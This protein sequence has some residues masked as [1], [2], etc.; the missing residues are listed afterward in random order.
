METIT[1]N[2]FE[3]CFTKNVK[4][5]T[6]QH[7]WWSDIKEGKYQKEVEFLRDIYITNKNKY[8]D[9]KTTTLPVVNYQFTFENKVLNDNIIES[10]NLL[11][12]EVD[13]KNHPNFTID[14]IKKDKVYVYYKSLSNNG[15]HILVKTEGVTKD[16]FKNAFDFVVKEIGLTK[17]Y[18]KSAVK[19]TQASIMSY[20]PTLYINDNPFIFKFTDSFN[21]KDNKVSIKFSKSQKQ[22]EN[23]LEYKFKFSN[24]DNVIE[25][26]EFGEY[27]TFVNWNGINI[28]ECLCIPNS[29]NDGN[30]QNALLGYCNNLV[31]LNPDAN[32]QQVFNMM[33][34]VNK[35][36][37]VNPVNEKRIENI[38]DTIY[39]YKYTSGL[40]P[41]YTIRK[42]LFDKNSNK[43]LNK[44]EKLEIVN[45]ILTEKR[46]NESKT[47]IYEIIN[48]WDISTN[49]KI[50][51]TKVAQYYGMSKTTVNK[52]WN[53]FSEEIKKINDNYKEFKKIYK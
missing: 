45:Q 5:H 49:G 44:T 19:M 2:K 38:V 3:N 48:N 39:K 53:E 52:Y 17:Y 46:V 11:F 21:V 27:N 1:L 24:I 35:S 13:G 8:D 18:D 34:R 37:C 51:Q 28:I 30:R 31:I 42:I 15:Y 36:M 41:K 33:M 40:Q 26:T 22:D 9:L 29:I 20:D 16:N 14:E 47:K 50:S 32:K 7:T 12:L 23:D 4:L 10:T 43:N 25:N 6:T